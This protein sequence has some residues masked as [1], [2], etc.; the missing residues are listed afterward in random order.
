MDSLGQKQ[1][2]P[3][4]FSPLP[5]KPQESLHQK[6]APL[7]CEFVG[8]SMLVFTVGCCVNTG[9][10]LWNAMAIASILMVSVY[11]FG[12]VSG[13]H[14]NPAVSL[15]IFLSKKMPLHT[16]LGYWVAQLFGGLVGGN[17]AAITFN[18]ARHIGPP[19]QPFS[20]YDAGIVEALYTAMIAFV[21][22]SCA[23]T[24]RPSIEKNQFFA[25]AIG[26]VVVAGGYAAGPVSGAMF[27]PAVSIGL[28]FSTGDAR[29]EML[30]PFLLSQMI[31]GLIAAAC[32]RTVRPDEFKE[33]P[34]FMPYSLNTKLASEF[35]G[36]WMLTF[37]TALAVSAGCPAWAFS[38]AACSMCM[39]YSLSDVSKGFFNPAITLAVVMSGS[40]F[41]ERTK[42]YI[43]AHEGAAF[44]GIQLLAGILASFVA[45][46]I[47]KEKP[48]PVAIQPPMIVNGWFQNLVGEV[49]FTFLIAIVALA[50]TAHSELEKLSGTFASSASFRTVFQVGLSV[51]LCSAVGG[52]AMDSFDKSG[53]SLNPAVSIGIA[54]ASVMKGGFWWSCQKF[55]ILEM[56]GGAIAAITFRFTHA[57]EFEPLTLSQY[58]SPPAVGD[59]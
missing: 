43:Q 11:A 24:G 23:V 41:R 37:T 10:T 1:L 49:F 56:L 50:V 52:I 2:A 8:T 7:I 29:G 22:L 25:L 55:A 47:Y 58:I 13:G 14:L 57:K 6:I 31:G 19:L 12:P 28:E 4:Q 46:G 40:S 36:T 26:F 30:G 53:G 48:E 59:A 16:M 42:T 3:Q 54:S 9:S 38:A 44:M 45:A 35:I 21:V 15:A 27:N 51:G 34:T 39:I 33:I 32:Y 17:A 5:L 18:T 20:Y